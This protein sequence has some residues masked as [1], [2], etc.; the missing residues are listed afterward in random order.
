VG[1]AIEAI[2]VVVGLVG[3]L[4]IA[5]VVTAWLNDRRHAAIDRRNPPLEP[6]EIL[7]RRFALGE[8][9]EAEF[10][11]RMHRLTYGPPLELD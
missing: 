3:G 9:D 8:I 5:G 1:E 11:R 4:G 2:F 7:E 10:N 6:K